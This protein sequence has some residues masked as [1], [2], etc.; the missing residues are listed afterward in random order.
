MRANGVCTGAVEGEEG[1]LRVDLGDV[2]ASGGR[3]RLVVAAPLSARAR[4]STRP[5]RVTAGFG[6][7]RYSP[8]SLTGTGSPGQATSACAA[9]PDSTSARRGPRRRRPPGRV[10]RAGDQRTASLRSRPSA[11]NSASQPSGISSAGRPGAALTQTAGTALGEREAPVE[12]RLGQARRG[13][14]CGTPAGRGGAR[15][16]A[17]GRVDEHRVEA[18]EADVA[19]VGHD[20]ADVAP[21]ARRRR[22]CA[23]PAGRA[24]RSRST[25][26]TSRPAASAIRS[27]PIPQHR[28][29]TRPALRR[30]A[31][32][33]SA[34]SAPTTTARTRPW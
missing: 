21:P 16:G 34:R 27:P 28:S 31:R 8:G 9:E 33:G 15:A 3:R 24:R 13:T 26:S 30:T 2:A 12:R 23:G 32:P 29:A 17:A 10:A 5:A 4:S 19:D 20:R 6:S 22:R 7:S 18:G 14:A 25:A 11:M 1:D